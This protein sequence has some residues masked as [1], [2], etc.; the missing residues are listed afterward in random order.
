[1]RVTAHDGSLCRGSRLEACKKNGHDGLHRH[2]IFDDMLIALSRSS[3]LAGRGGSISRHDH[4]QTTGNSD[5]VAWARTSKGTDKPIPS[6][7]AGAGV[8]HDA[9]ALTSMGIACSN[10]TP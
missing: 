8:L 10:A 1:M 6:Y 5:H 2:G 3:M 7:S 9:K 4:N